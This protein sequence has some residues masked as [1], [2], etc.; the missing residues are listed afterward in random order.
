MVVLICN[1]RIIFLQSKHFVLDYSNAQLQD[2]N[3][4]YYEQQGNLYVADNNVKVFD[5]FQ[6]GNNEKYN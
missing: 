1:H 2:P 5:Q 3:T 4:D 6:P